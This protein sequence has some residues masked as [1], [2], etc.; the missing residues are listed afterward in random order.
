MSD[1]LFAGES[2]EGWIFVVKLL[3]AYGGCLGI[4]RLGVEVC[5]KLGVADKRALIPRYLC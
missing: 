5:E 3:R 4:R 1:S 2:G